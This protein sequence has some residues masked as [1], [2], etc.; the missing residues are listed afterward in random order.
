MIDNNASINSAHRLICNSIHNLEPG[1]FDIAPQ[2]IPIGP[3]LASNRL[4]SS[5]GHLWKPEPDCLEWLDQQPI[6]SV[7]YI[8]FGSVTMFNR[9]QFQELALGL[10]KADRPFLWVVRPG[11]SSGLEGGDFPE[12]FL[13]RVSNQGKMVQWAPQQEVLSHGSIA[14]FVSHCGWNSTVES[15]SNG[16]PILC[17][18]YFA[19]QF[20]NQSYICDIWKVGLRLEHDS[21]SGNITCEEIKEKIDCLI[22]DDVFKERALEL[23]EMILISAREGGNS[24]NNLSNFISWIKE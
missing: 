12:G 9:A 2:V 1:A 3:L 8:A 11:I 18:P 10:E 13:D 4:T 19:D 23:K 22:G 20:I 6:R 21:S 16:V 24:Y 14:C 15:V 7:I 5:A 17:W